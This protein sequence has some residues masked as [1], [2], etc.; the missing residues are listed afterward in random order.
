MESEKRCGSGKDPNVRIIVFPPIFTNQLGNSITIAEKF[1]PKKNKD[2]LEAKKSTPS[3]PKINCSEKI[4]K[5]KSA[6]KNEIK[7]KVFISLS[8]K[9]TLLVAA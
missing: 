7:K 1:L 4:N 8:R 2:V 5:E 3:T 9:R 6:D